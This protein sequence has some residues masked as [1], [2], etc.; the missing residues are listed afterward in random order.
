MEF[1]LKEVENI[2]LSTLASF[3]SALALLGRGPYV[4]ITKA[5][6]FLFVVRMH[7]SIAYIKEEYRKIVALVRIL[8]HY[9]KMQWTK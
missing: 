9:G 4:N 2:S 5:C 1:L 6:Q 8:A 7:F 3:Y